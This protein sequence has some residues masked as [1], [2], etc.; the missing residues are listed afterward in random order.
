MLGRRLASAAV[1]ISVLI[2][3]IA[4]DLYLGRDSV[5]GRSG[6]IVSPVCIIVAMMFAGEM[7]SL[8]RQHCANL[9]SLANVLIAGMSVAICSIP[10]LWRDYPVDCSIGMFGW[11]MIALTFSVGMTVLLNVI[12]YDEN[13]FASAVCGYSVLI[14]VQAILLFGFFVAHR[15]LFFDNTTGMLAL[16]TLITSV[17]MSDAAAY[18]VGRA[19]GKRKLAAN[20]SP[21]KTVEGFVGGFFGAILGTAIVVYVVENLLLP[22][23]PV[24]P[25]W[26]V[27]V[28]SI[29]IT[30]AGVV[31]DLTESMF[32]RDAK[33]K[34]SSSWVPGLGG[35]L[36]ITDSLVFAAPI[37]FFLWILTK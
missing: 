21:G 34:D 17:K 33:I 14:H 12:Q 11:T 10:V 30:I 36:D 22:I 8:F 6:L 32:K 37:S 1:I 25:V 27:L 15:L 26:W 35:V 13:R 16:I 28:Y 24:I 20:L 5:L 23:E 18:F 31:G 2:G 29:S 4:I 19:F 3:L 7:T 9:A